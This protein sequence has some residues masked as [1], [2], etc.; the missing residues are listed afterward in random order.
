MKEITFRIRATNEQVEQM[1]RQCEMSEQLFAL[2]LAQHLQGKTQEEAIPAICDWFKTVRHMAQANYITSGIQV[3]T[4]ER[5]RV[6]AVRQFL[7]DEDI[8]LADSQVERL[9]KLLQ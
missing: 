8:M 6:A 2:T 4:N 5:D 1:N 3:V 7:H 9:F